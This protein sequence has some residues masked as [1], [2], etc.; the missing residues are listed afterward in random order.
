MR[1]AATACGGFCTAPTTRKGN[2]DAL[3][4]SGIVGR[5]VKLVAEAIPRTSYPLRQACGSATFR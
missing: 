3:G 5:D 1:T 4:P 2:A